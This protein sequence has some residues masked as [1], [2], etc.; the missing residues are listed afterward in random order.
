MNKFLLILFSLFFSVSNLTAQELNCQVEI[1]TQKLQNVSNSVFETLKDAISEYMNSNKFSEAQIAANEKI[2]C[3]M[4]LTVSEYEDNMV[5]GTLQVQS[6][7]PVYNSNY[8]TTVVNFLDSKIDFSYTEGEPLNFNLSGM[9][10][11]LT[12]VLNFYA[13]LF[14]AMDFD[15]FAPK[16][17]DQ[18]WE[19]LKLIVQ[20]AQ[21]SGEV[22]WKAFEDNKNRSAILDAFTSPQTEQM[23][24]FTYRYH[25]TGLD[26]MAQSPD[27]GRANITETLDILKAVYDVS[28]MSVGLS[29]TRDAKL[30]ELVNVYSKAQQTERERVY[31]TL[32]PL[33]PTENK[34]LNEIKR[35]PQK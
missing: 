12:Q 5:K 15:S 22:G 30:D 2:D 23:R 21:S 8:T 31:E 3:R 17:G 34:R 6:S 7:R 14:L 28:P 10:N 19:R 11:Q 26:E 32:Y 20:D 29:M 27:K 24:D 18:F 4:L 35:G 13:Y 16:G 33:W 1:N 25:R 9:E